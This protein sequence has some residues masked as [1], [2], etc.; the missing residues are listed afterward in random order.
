MQKT[1]N[2]RAKVAAQTVL[3][4]STAKQAGLQSARPQIPSGGIGTAGR[5]ATPE[6]PAVPIT[7][8]L[9]LT[10]AINALVTYRDHLHLLL[11]SDRVAK[12]KLEQILTEWSSSK[13]AKPRATTTAPAVTG[14]GAGL[15]KKPI[16]KPTGPKPVGQS[17]MQAVRPPTKIPPPA[18]K[19]TLSNEAPTPK[20]KLPPPPAKPSQRKPKKL[21]PKQAERFTKALAAHP[22]PASGRRSQEQ[23]RKIL[24][25][26]GDDPVLVQQARAHI[27]RERSFETFTLRGCI[28]TTTQRRAYLKTIGETKK[29]PGFW[30]PEVMTCKGYTFVTTEDCD[31]KWLRDQLRKFGHDVRVGIQYDDM[32]DQEL[33]KWLIP[34]AHCS[35]ALKRPR[36]LKKHLQKQL[37]RLSID[38]GQC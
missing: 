6:K 24:K 34:Q 12:D 26:L 14:S 7:A 16:E 33:R 25:Q 2:T 5:P 8:K 19:T 36:Q 38:Y 32:Q 1:H 22:A 20:A 37:S 27:P 23:F 3:M 18:V 17:E 4:P 21:T 30:I 15:K 35:Q 29:D 28:G 13:L 31:A 11:E 10:H 9:R